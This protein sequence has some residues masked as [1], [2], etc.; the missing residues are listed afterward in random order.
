MLPPNRQL[1]KLWD[2][3]DITS[4]KRVFQ[5]ERKTE[6]V[7][8]Y[9]AREIVKL[10]EQWFVDNELFISE[11]MYQRY[12]QRYGTPQEN[13][14]MVTGVW[15]I[16]ICYSVQKDDKFYFK[17][18]NILWFKAKYTQIDSRFVQFLFE[19]HLVKSQIHN[20]AG[21][22]VATLTIQKAKEIQIP[23]P[24]L[25]EQ[26]KIVA[27]LDELNTTITK[28]KAEYQSQLTALDEM[29]NG[30]LDLAFWCSREW[31]LN[32]WKSV[33]LGDVAEL[34]PKKSQI[35]SMSDNLEISFV[36][37]ADLSQETPLFDPKE[38]RTL[39]EVRKW[40]TYFQDND[41]LLAKVTPCFENGKCGIAKN[42]KNGIGFWSSEF[43][44]FRMTKIILPEYFYYFVSSKS[45]RKEWEKNMWWAVGLQRVK[46]DR[47]KNIEIPVPDLATQA[48][49]I[50]HLDQV[51]EH[52]TALKAQV[53]QQIQHCDELWQ[54]SL[55]QVLSQGL[56]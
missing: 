51:H 13:D 33:K 14:I 11:E 31:D 37:M 22:V 4:S 12:S 15:T 35:S 18:W 42:L 6:G 45:F 3:Y 39:G 28:L 23:L 29:R 38:I 16:G 21:S 9:R 25:E 55:E 5:S 47:L 30:S 44:V 52:I 53:N 24:P 46:Q 19:S 26:K 40:Y 1:K 56:K 48:R 8:F 54:S 7:P 10:S 20:V 50:A 32:N 27:Y 41:V 49:I 17:D 36:P 2:I 43:F 34:W